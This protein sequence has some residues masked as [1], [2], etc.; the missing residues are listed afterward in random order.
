MTD[1]PDTLA[2]A[3]DDLCLLAEHDHL[4][5]K[6]WALDIDELRDLVSRTGVA[7]RWRS[8]LLRQLDELRLARAALS[9]HDQ[10]DP[11]E[12]PWDLAQR[13]NPPALGGQPDTDDELLHEA[14][15][16]RR[17]YTHLPSMRPYVELVHKLAKALDERRVQR[18]HNYRM[19][20]K[21]AARADGLERELAD[22]RSDAE[23]LRAE[24][25]FG[26]GSFDQF[27]EQILEGAGDDWDD[28]E[29]TTS[30]AIAYVRRLERE[31]AEARSLAGTLRAMQETADEQWQEFS[32]E[33][34]ANAGDE[35][36]G[37]DDQETI[38]I[39]Y[40]RHLEAEAR[41]HGE[42]LARGVTHERAGAG[43]SRLP[44]VWVKAP[45]GTDVLVVRATAD[46]E[47]TGGR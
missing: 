47:E 32:N 4:V 7:G 25:M 13:A 27:A 11:P 46:Q 16:F 39:R 44:W 18:D 8:R 29:A 40:V 6:S 23:K 15:E 22:Q 14:W 24:R 9:A 19:Y 5:T 26:P 17:T 31:L 34:V 41:S 21:C 36:D 20:G 2:E 1:H 28:G 43:K 37:D 33:I 42:V 12:S 45:P 3:A 30:Q 38:A 35:W 10:H